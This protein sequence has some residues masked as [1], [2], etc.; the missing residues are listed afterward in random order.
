MPQVLL[1]GFADEIG[2]DPDLQ[3][4]TLIET[5]VKHVELRGVWG[6]NVLD[7]D[8]AQI[9][10][11]RAALEGAG[12]GVSAIGSPIGKVQIRADLEAHFERFKVAAE[13]AHQFNTSYIRVFSFYHQGESAETVRGEVLA[14]F[15]RM[16]AWAE[17]EDV[18]LLH[19]NESRIYGDVPQRCLDLVESIGHPRLRAIF[20]PSNFIQCGADPLQQAWPMLA[21]YVDY[22]HIKDAL[23]ASGKV[24]PAGFGDGGLAEI[25][26]QAIKNGF[27]GFLSL[28]PHLKADD[29]VHGGSGAER[30]AK[31]SAALKDLLEGLGLSPG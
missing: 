24:V 26:G 4:E 19:E 21:K 11:F 13:R 16:V 22:F 30:F 14:Q 3:I 1:S 25:L 28:E 18:I 20:D 5:G 17:S 12:I 15:E 29:P 8:K 23:A 31:A 7:L 9:R 2:P 27:A 10:S 6:K